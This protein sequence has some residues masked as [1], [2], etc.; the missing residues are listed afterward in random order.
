MSDLRLE[1]IDRDGLVV[2]TLGRLQGRTRA[3]FLR[4]A[5]VGSG[6]LLAAFAAPAFAEED[7]DPRD[8]SILNF[9]LALEEL[10]AR[11]SPARSTSRSRARRR[12]RS[13]TASTSSWR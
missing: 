6:A 4:R 8:I 2:E 7:E 1:S 3:D 11:R 5:L 12:R 10:Q 9:I 13:S